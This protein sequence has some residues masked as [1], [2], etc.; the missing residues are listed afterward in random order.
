[1]SIERYI[2]G[3][4]PGSRR[5]HELEDRYGIH[6]VAVRAC[7][8][9]CGYPV[10]FTTSGVQAIRERDPEVICEECRD[11]YYPDLQREL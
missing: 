1:M 8:A 2:V 3:Y 10:H 11:R 5:I 6:T 7:I 9:G 4:R